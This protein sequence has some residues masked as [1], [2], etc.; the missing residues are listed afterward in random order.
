MTKPKRGKMSL[1]EFASKKVPV[2]KSSSSAIGVNPARGERGDFKRITITMSPEMLA[3]L[4][5]LGARRQAK[6]EKNT[7]VSS[8][9]REAVAE[10]L[11]AL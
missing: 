1:D 3:E 4:K 6:G 8:L 7:D 2:E 10:M 11:K 5:I 9:I